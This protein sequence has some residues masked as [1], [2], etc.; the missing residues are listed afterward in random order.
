MGQM[1]KYTVEVQV[2]RT[3]VVTVESP[4]YD[5]SP[6]IAE[7]EAE[8]LLP[9]LTESAPEFRAHRLLKEEPV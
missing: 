4:T 8:R 9:T 2:I 5:E 7:D 1:R 3:V 6:D